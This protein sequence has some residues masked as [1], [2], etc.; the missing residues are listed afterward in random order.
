MIEN[1]TRLGFEPRQTEPKSVVLPLHYRAIGLLIQV[2][3]KNWEKTAEI[4]QGGDR[5]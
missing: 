5:T 4:R 1:I 3:T 2:S